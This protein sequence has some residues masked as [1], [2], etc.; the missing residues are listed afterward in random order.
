M[1]HRS[2]NLRDFRNWHVSKWN[3]EETVIQVFSNLFYY[4][5]QNLL[6][7]KCVSNFS[8]CLNSQPP[9]PLRPLR[10]DYICLLYRHHHI[11]NL[12]Q[13]YPSAVR[14]RSCSPWSW[15]PRPF[16]DFQSQIFCQVHEHFHHCTCTKLFPSFLEL[17]KTL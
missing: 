14:D 6:N 10:R 9:F 11:R 1:W 13:S 8:S 4:D 7:Y 5:N 12:I 16:Q 3:K 17:L 15:T 2:L